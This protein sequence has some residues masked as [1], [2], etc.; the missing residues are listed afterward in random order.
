METYDT[1]LSEQCS[2]QGLVY[3]PGAG[4]FDENG[5]LFIVS[6]TDAF[7]VDLSHPKFVDLEAWHSLYVGSTSASIY[8]SPNPNDGFG[9]NITKIELKTEDLPDLREIS[10]VA[11]EVEAENE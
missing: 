5:A 8:R 7:G 1:Y 3:V 9:K 6:D 4:V 11:G 2:K 10:R